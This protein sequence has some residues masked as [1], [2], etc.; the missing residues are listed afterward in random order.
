M[1]GFGIAISSHCNLNCKGCDVY[2]PLAKKE[3]VSYDQFCKDMKK[4]KDLAP[5]RDFDTIFIGGE[6]LLN[7]ELVQIMYK[8]DEFFPNGKRAIL[9]NGLLEKI[10]DDFGQ[11][12]KD[13]KVKF[14]ITKYP[15][16]INF[17]YIEKKLKNMV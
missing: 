9:T 12:I 6:P 11:A 1:D 15:I 14:G 4:L 5:D 8:A 13:T 17:K 10:G 7:P 3:F 2:A 16:N